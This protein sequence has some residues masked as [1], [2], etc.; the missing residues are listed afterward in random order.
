ME[1][2]LIVGRSVASNRRNLELTVLGSCTYKNP[3]TGDSCTE[4]RG[5]GWTTD[6][7]T[8]RCSEESSS[9]FTEGDGCAFDDNTAGYCVK[10]VT[11]DSFEYNLLVLSATADC[12][13]NKMACETFVGGSFTAS[14]A[15][16]ASDASTYADSSATSNPPVSDFS[17]IESESNATSSC[18]IAPGAIGAAHQAAF[19]SGYRSD[20]S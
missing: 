5:T 3:F 4:F 20:N 17:T 10:D 8:E 9:T 14:S 19:S 1:L 6:S 13:A 16:G 12:D 2:G 18:G 7:M 15:C 11:G